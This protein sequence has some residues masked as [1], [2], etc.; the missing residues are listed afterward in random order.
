M[1]KPWYYSQYPDVRIAQLDP[2]RH[3]IKDGYR[4]GR[5]LLPPMWFIIY[6]TQL[7]SLVRNGKSL[8]LLNKV[9]ANTIE[10]NQID[11]SIF[12][13]KI[14]RSNYR[15][16]RKFLRKYLRLI[17]LKKEVNMHFK[18]ADRSKS[19]VVSRIKKSQV[20]IE[21][22]GKSELKKFDVEFIQH[23]LN[24]NLNYK[25]F[26][27]EKVLSQDSIRALFKQIVNTK[28]QKFFKEP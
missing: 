4:E 17:D 9:D 13:I 15:I 1:I 27:E 2:I 7:K 23:I 16:K 11:C 25:V 10:I 20:Q 22:P 26:Y 18:I 3:W 5:Y 12:N 6:V 28:T 21:I 24:T 19:T 8:M 14:Y